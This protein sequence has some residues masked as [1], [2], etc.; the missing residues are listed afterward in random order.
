MPDLFDH[1][2][3]IETQFTE[4]ALAQQ[5]ERTKHKPLSVSATECKECG[6]DIPELRRIHVQGCQYCIDCQALLEQGFLS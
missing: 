6:Q 3:G 1:A 2:S 4:L 5:L